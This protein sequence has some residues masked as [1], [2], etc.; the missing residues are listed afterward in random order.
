MTKRYNYK[1]LPTTGKARV[2][3][4]LGFALGGVIFFGYIAFFIFVSTSDLFDEREVTYVNGTDETLTVY[5]D[6]VSQFTIDPGETVVKDHFRIE[7]WFERDVSATDEA[8]R[9]V[10]ER[11][12]KDDDLQDLDWR[13]V[14]Q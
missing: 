9:V 4:A 11:S 3:L 10:W 8:G 1:I 2:L 12:L 14:I 6:D 13:I 7:W 5:I